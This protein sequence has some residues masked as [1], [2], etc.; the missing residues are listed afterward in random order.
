[1]TVRDDIKSKIV[2]SGLTITD[3]VQK[4]N[5]ECDRTETIQN[6]SNK[7]T[8]GT[9]RYSEVL[10]IAKVAGYRIEWVKENK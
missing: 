8:R 6:L 3:V 9:I 5:A 4:I 10:E 2:Q 7:L 1:M